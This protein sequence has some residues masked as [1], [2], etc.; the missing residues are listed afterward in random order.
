MSKQKPDPELE[1]LCEHLEYRRIP[2][3]AP[4]C[5]NTSCEDAIPFNESYLCGR[6]YKG[7]KNDA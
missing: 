2:H 5:N 6:M 3:N 7:A 4:C 1:K